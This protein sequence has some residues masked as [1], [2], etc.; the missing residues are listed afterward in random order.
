MYDP[1]WGPTGKWLSA[2]AEAVAALAALATVA[3]IHAERKH[4]AGVAGRTDARVN[5]GQLRAG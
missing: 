1:F 3:M 2:I 4:A 5:R